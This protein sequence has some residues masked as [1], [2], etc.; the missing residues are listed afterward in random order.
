MRL[1]R[2]DKFIKQRAGL[3][4]YISFG[5]MGILIVGLLILRSAVI[6]P[7]FKWSRVRAAVTDQRLL[8]RYD[9]RGRV[10]WDVPLVG[11]SDVR[12]SR[13][14]WQR[15]ARAGSIIVLSPM[16]ASPVV[17]PNVGRVAA[18][19]TAIADLRARAWQRYQQ[20]C[21]RQS[22]AEQTDNTAAHRA[23]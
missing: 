21:Y 12:H 10:G 9:R 7:F 6:R 2:N 23:A 3:G 17:I 5:G 20:D 4:R 11:I 16:I 13:G 15:I 1:I 8:I 19:E 14:P 22:I 18:H